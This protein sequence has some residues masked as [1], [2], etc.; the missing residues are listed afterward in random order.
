MP[1]YQISL[2]LY[3][4]R[5]FPTLEPVLATLK[6]IGYDAVEP[7]LPNYSD[8]PAGFRRKM[9]AAGLACSG[10]HMPLSGLNGEMGK[11]PDRH[12]EDDRR[13]ADDP[14]VGSR[15]RRAIRSPTAGSGSAR[16][17]G[18]APRRRRRQA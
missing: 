1:R 2:G 7:F 3:S 15:R 8:D 12:R 10:F 17:S 6:A 4:V 16:R 14:P 5:Q 18:G 13:A 11:I 9:D